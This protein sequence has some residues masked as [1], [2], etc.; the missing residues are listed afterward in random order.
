MIFQ[1]LKIDEAFLQLNYAPHLYLK[2]NQNKF[3]IPDFKYLEISK[4]EIESF[5]TELEEINQNLNQEDV[6][7]DKYFEYLSLIVMTGEM[8]FLPLIKSF[9]WIFNQCGSWSTTLNFIYK[10][11]KENIFKTKTTFLESF[12]LNT[13]TINFSTLEIPNPEDIEILLSQFPFTV[14][15]LKKKQ[16]L[17]ELEEVHKFLNFRDRLFKLSND[18][19]L[20]TTNIYKQIA[21]TLMEERKL[22]NINDI[23]FLEMD[24][25]KNIINDSFF[26][27]IVFT[28]SFKHWQ[29]Q[30]FELQQ[31]PYEIFEKDIKDTSEIIEKLFLKYNNTKILKCFSLFHKTYDNKSDYLITETAKLKDIL[32]LKS[33]AG[34]ITSVSS[35]FSFVTEYACI[36]NIPVYTGIRYSEY[37]LKNKKFKIEKDF[38][39]L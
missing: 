31:I 3:K 8:I 14:R 33:F 24:E 20:K 21:K 38:I 10:T 25:I 12:N 37:L 17:F 18:F 11:R 28:K 4:D 26:G 6:N 22:K 34:L 9:I 32:Q 15:T 16:L 35:F 1:T 36:S 7:S 39:E 13:A 23:F 29:T 19:L 5:F 2:H 27:N 30:R